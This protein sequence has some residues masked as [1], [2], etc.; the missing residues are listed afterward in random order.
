MKKKLRVIVC[1][2]ANLDNNPRPNRMVNYFKDKTEYEVSYL[3]FNCTLPDIKF[4]KIKENN[5]FHIKLIRLFS[6]LFRLFTVIEKITYTIDPV[7]DFNDYELVICHD[8]KL[9]PYILKSKRSFKIIF[10]AREYYP[11]HFED[12][13][14]WKIINAPFLDYLCKKHLSKIDYG[15]TVSNGLKKGYS[16]NYSID[17]DIFYSL[18][19]YINLPVRKVGKIIRFIYH[20]NSNESRKIEQLIYAMDNANANILLDLMLVGNKNDVKKLLLLT[21]YRSN[22]RVIEAVSFNEIIITLNKYDAGVIFYPP[23]SFNLEYCMPNKLFECIQA[24]IPVIVAPLTDLKKFVIS[25]KIGV[26][27]SG[28][29]SLSLAESFNDLDSDTLYQFKQQSDK[30]AKIYNQSK[31]NKAM[32]IIIK[33][34]FLNTSTLSN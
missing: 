33:Q 22:V 15:I 17:M 10:D 30:L 21:K 24:R 13:R 9:L 23:S 28:F 4:F 29:N 18:P 25:N 19:P 34:L 31:N 6:K 2:L 12:K 1:A 32:D 14:I 16:E 5:Y 27:S 11:K 7:I 26:V 20:G 8:I 3:G